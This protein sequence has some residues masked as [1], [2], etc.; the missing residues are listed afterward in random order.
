MEEAPLGTGGSYQLMENP[1]A[2]GGSDALETTKVTVRLRVTWD[3]EST[4]LLPETCRQL[5]R[6][7]LCWFGTNLSLSSLQVCVGS[8]K[9]TG[10]SPQR[11]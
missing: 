2:P 3:A 10:D 5:R 7:S 9:V 4:E 6:S 11:R 1:A 8:E